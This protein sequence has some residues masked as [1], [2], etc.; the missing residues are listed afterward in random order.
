M[1]LGILASFLVVSIALST[2]SVSHPLFP[3]HP[4]QDGRDTDSPTTGWHPRRHE[5]G[6]IDDTGSNTNPVASDVEY[7][8]PSHFGG[9]G[10][11]QGVDQ[12]SAVSEHG[13]TNL[14]GKEEDTPEAAVARSNLRGLTERERMKLIDLDPG[15]FAAVPPNV[16]RG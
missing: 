5:H 15:S 10:D 8:T 1:L 14:L 4:H 9:G 13:G 2:S 7:Q 16:V 11:A 12:A 3:E 6:T